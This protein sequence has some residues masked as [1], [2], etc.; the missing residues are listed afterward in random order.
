MHSIALTVAYNGSS[1]HGWQYQSPTTATIQGALEAALSRIAAE[2]LRIKCAGRTDAGVHATHQ[3]VSFRTSA[4]RPDKA[5]VLGTN[6]LLPDDIAV[7]TATPVPSDFDAR[8]SAVSRHYLYVIYN[9]RVRSPLLPSLLTREPRMMDSDRMHQAAQALIGEHDFSSYRAANCQSRT[10]MRNLQSIRVIRQDRLVMIEVS[11]NAFLHHMVR[12]I[13]GVLMDVGAG[14]KDLSWPAQL[15]AL[16]D[17]TKGGKT[18]S[19]SGLYLVG[20]SYGVDVPVS[21]VT[22]PHFLTPP[23][24]P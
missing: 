19:P 8:F 20:V 2:P 24:Q 4:K 18:A 23:G 7:V 17:R 9:D 12:N 21:A 14:E 22:W 15:L 3:V 11:A 10:P 6:A 13:A 5:W 16:R 1:Y